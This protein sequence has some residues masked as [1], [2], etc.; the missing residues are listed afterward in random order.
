MP[1][2]PVKGYRHEVWDSADAVRDDSLV[3]LF[4]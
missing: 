3:V 4:V 2:K 1:A